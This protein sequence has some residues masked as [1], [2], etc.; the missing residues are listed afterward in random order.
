M[1]KSIFVSFL[2]LLTVGFS[3]GAE[4][5]ATVSLQRLG[6]KLVVSIHH[7][8]GWHT[9][10][11]N[12][13][14][15]GLPTTFKFSADNRPLELKSFEWPTPTK[16]IEAGDILTIGYSG[17]KHFFFENRPVAIDAHITFLIC[18]D[19]CIPGEARLKLAPG[20]EFASSR[21]AKPYEKE[22]LQK[23]FS[24][25]P[26]L[27]EK[28]KEFEYYLTRTKGQNL[29]T[30]HY[31][32]KGITNKKFPHDLGFLTAF[33]HPPFGFKREQ[34]FS[35]G[36]T[37]YGKIDIEWDGEYQDP[38]LPLPENGEFPGP[39]E[40][41]FLYNSPKRESVEKI[42]LSLKNFTNSTP[43]LDQFYKN[44]KPFDP[45]GKT[46]A[47]A[48]GSE[49]DKSFFQYLLFAFLGGLILNLM[50][51]VLPVI[52]LK[53]FG[54]IKHRNAPRQRLI[55]HNL[56]FTA[57]VI[58]TFMALA[59]VVV[60]IKA[61]GEEIG[62][63]FQLQSPAF[64]LIMML[65]LFI[66]SLNLFGLYEFYTP[67][68]SKLGGAQ[69][70]EGLSGDFFT[71]ILTTILATPCSAPF[72]GTALTF[73]FTTST[74][75]IFIMFFMIGLGLS[76]PFLLTAAFP[77]SLF[78]FPR[79]GAWMEKLKYFLGLALLGTAIWLYDVFVSLVHF[80]V[81]SWKLNLLFALWF[82]A[83]YFAQKISK[84]KVLQFVVFAVPLSLTVIAIQNLEVRP[85]NAA[86]VAASSS[87]WIPWTEEKMMQEEAPVFVDF[88]AEWCLTCKV[89]K[90]LVMETNGFESLK[91]KY[92]LVTMRADWTKR[93]DRITEFLRRHGAV[94]VPAYFIQ[95]GG[96]L[97]SLGETISLGEIEEHLK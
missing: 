15:A 50:P 91:E 67:G 36:D 25:L 58:S 70:E 31:S 5:H 44:L 8:S 77:G 48:T 79:P 24:K 82:F 35:E 57:G 76:F 17:V 18:K 16:Y 20:Q 39:Y 72:L 47:Q 71:G 88:T 83:F 53:L 3:F 89:N 41:S 84:R 59:L 26:Q 54:L 6:E 28:P 32:L 13:G 10:W 95:T 27:I 14:D 37:L 97:I 92:G 21:V 61:T 90:K 19:I 22:E 85:T 81:L 4:D 40:L 80:E 93:D 46:V 34:L 42:Q 64:I 52:S 23:A 87:S 69:V 38:P 86:E 65:I 55:A 94:G 68:G 66:L 56:S 2:V 7:E 63:G 75:N 9:Y 74:A 30:L 78:F 43:T 51:C 49:D 45:G 29:L 1:L 96:K 11:K 33:P 60:G 73:A 62:W 12:P